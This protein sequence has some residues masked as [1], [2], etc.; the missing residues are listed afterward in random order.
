LR[1]R[2]ER[3]SLSAFC[4]IGVAKWGA[5]AAN[6]AWGD[7]LNFNIFLAVFIRA[8]PWLKTLLDSASEIIYPPRHVRYRPPANLDRRRQAHALAEVSLTSPN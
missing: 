5:A 1:K 4:G 6:M 3:F 8:H 2:C 7:V